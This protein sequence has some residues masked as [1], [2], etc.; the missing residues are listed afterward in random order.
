VLERLRNQLSATFGD[1]AGTL[2]RAYAHILAGISSPFAD[3][4]D[5]ASRMQCHQVAG[6]FTD[7]LGRFACAL[8]CAFADVTAAPA[9]ITAAA[10]SPGWGCGRGLGGPG[11]G[12]TG[13]RGR[14]LSLGRI[15]AVSGKAK[16]QRRQ[17]QQ[18]DGSSHQLPPQ[19][20]MSG[21]TSM[22]IFST[23]SIWKAS[24]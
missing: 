2:D 8:A 22:A 10:S 11:L 14:H 3:V 18:C 7:A 12:S 9:D 1:L 16:S 20:W 21:C 19:N 6:S 13:L 23:A 4:P 5:R 24:H 17:K 15:L